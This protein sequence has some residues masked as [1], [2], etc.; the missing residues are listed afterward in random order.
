MLVLVGGSTATFAVS[1]TSNSENYEMTEMQFGAGS[2]LESCSESY[3]ARAS[4][5]DIAGGISKAGESSAAF[6]PITPEEPLLEVIV[7]PGD[8]NLGVLTTEK[9]ATKTTTVRIR[10]YLSEGYT[11]Q[12]TGTP[13]KYKDHTLATPTTPTESRPGTEQFGINVA[14]NTSPQVGTNPVQVPSDQISFGQ[15]MP[16]YMTPNFFKYVSG[17]VIARSQTES[18]RTDYTISMIVNVSNKT[19]AGNFNGEFSAVVIP[20]Y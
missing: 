12:L 1:S 19:P 2:S 11:L 10:S 18:G 7:D 9:T 13:P 20:V 5:G 8:S 4:I 3:C 14:A 16:D 6:G 17:D 15:A